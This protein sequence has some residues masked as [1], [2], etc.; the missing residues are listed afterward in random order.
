M[1]E[2]KY[3]KVAVCFDWM[4]KCVS[5]DNKFLSKYE[6]GK[7]YEEYADLLLEKL[8]DKEK[9]INQFNLAMETHIDNSNLNGAIKIKEKLGEYYKSISEYEKAIEMYSSA[10]NIYSNKNY[11]YI[12]INKMLYELY[13]L[14]NNFEKAYNIYNSLITNDKLNQYATIDYVFGAMLNYI[15]IDYELSENKYHQY[16]SSYP[17]FANDRKGKLIDS[18]LKSLAHNDISEFENNIREFESMQSNKFSNT[19]LILFE[20][21]KKQFSDCMSLL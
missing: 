3:D 5:D 15:I 16:C 12:K 13:I 20:N 19:D 1:I 17:S 21:I 18:M 4:I 14:T 9:G 6:L 7:L 8:D 10:L 11:S 2:Q